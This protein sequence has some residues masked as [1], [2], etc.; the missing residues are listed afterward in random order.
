M[1]VFDPTNG[2]EKSLPFFHFWR[3]VNSSKRTFQTGEST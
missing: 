1:I 3:I 2:S